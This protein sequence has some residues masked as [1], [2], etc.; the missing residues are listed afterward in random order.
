M[1]I[2]NQSVNKAID[3]I[4]FNLGN[5]ICVEDVAKHCHLSKFHFNRL[6]KDQVGESIYAFI[7]RLRMESSAMRLGTDINKSITDIGLDYAYD[8]S[9]N[10]SSAFTKHHNISPMRLRKLKQDNQFDLRNPFDGT[11]FIYQ[12]FQYYMDR[13]KIK[14]RDNFFVLFE[15]HIGS[16]EDIAELWVNF[17]NNYAHLCNRETEFIVISYNDPNLGNKNRCLY[18]LCITVDKKIALDNI[19]MI[20]GG[21]YAAYYYQSPIKQLNQAYKGL[22]NVWIPQSKYEW[23]H[24]SS[25]YSYLNNSPENGLFEIIIY[26]PIK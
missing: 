5:D 6:F 18:D 7:K 21:I 10:Y 20:P 2:D 17:K 11:E 12:D 25:F 16:Y 8:S 22:F 19:K 9:S 14:K 24:R 23:D 4:I 3:Y 13:I 26:L 1:K 15:R